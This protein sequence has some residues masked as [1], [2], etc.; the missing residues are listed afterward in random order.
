MKV[1]IGI[2]ARMGSSRL[3]GKPLKDILGLSMIGHVYKRCSLCD[4]VDKVFVAA[5]D[6]E[7]KNEIKSLGGNVIMTDK[8]VA[9]CCD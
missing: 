9:F 5:C 1:L 3:P 8:L 6:D 4:S 2:P 7:I